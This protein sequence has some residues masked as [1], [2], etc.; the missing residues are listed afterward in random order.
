MYVLA[1][2][3]QSG[4]VSRKFFGVSAVTAT[5]AKVNKGLIITPKYTGPGAS[6]MAS[7]IEKKAIRV[8]VPETEVSIAPGQTIYVKPVYTEFTYNPEGDLSETGKVAFAGGT[9]TGGLGGKGG[10][11]GYGGGGGE[12]GGGGGGADESGSGD[13][14]HDGD[15]AVD[16]TG[17]GSSTGSGDP[18]AGAGGT[19]GGLAG[20]GGHGGA[21]GS[22]APGEDG[23]DPP[24]AGES[25][26]PTSV[27]IPAFTAYRKARAEYTV[28]LCTSAEI[29]CIPTVAD[30]E[31]L[32]WPIAEVEGTAE[33]P[34]IYSLHEG[35]IT[36][37]TPTKL[38]IAPS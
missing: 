9:V 4:V 1:R 23:T 15:A 20:N 32:Y 36:A 3:P 12:G 26:G 11:G 5:T 19:G 13:N 7:A 10:A 31:D 18:D 35:L 21:G 2:N 6:D 24:A 34:V 14:G 30:T 33:A 28:W 22:G 25:N 27:D 17:A 29:V 37:T 38:E 8:A 16:E